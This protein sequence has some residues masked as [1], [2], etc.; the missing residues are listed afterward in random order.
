MS[1]DKNSIVNEE[2]AYHEPFSLATVAAVLSS[3]LTLRF[4]G[5]Q[6]AGQKAYRRLESCTATA[7][8]RVL[9]ANIGGSAVV[10]GKIV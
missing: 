10:L 2:T 1:I 4:N 7:G 3:G 5:E 8:D 6:Q 9:V